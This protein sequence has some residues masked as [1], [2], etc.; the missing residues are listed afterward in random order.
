MDYTYVL[1][2]AFLCEKF[3]IPH[4]SLVST[5]GACSTSMFY[6][7]EVKG[8]AEE[9]LKNLHKQNKIETLSIIQPGAITDRDNDSRF[10][11]SVLKWTPFISKIKCNALGAG[12]VKEANRVHLNYDTYGKKSSVYVNKE[13]R[14]L[15]ELNI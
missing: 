11:E 3:N 14:V 10:G 8:K 6:Y 1:F 15:S 12:I 7:F 2:S 9:A 5:V 4:F 13:I